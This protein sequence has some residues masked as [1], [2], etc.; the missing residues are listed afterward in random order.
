MSPADDT[1]PEET[2]ID[3]S[4]DTETPTGTPTDTETPTET[5]TETETETATD[6]E[7]PTETATEAEPATNGYQVRISYDGEWSGSIGGGGS[8]RS[9][10]G[11]G[12]QTLDVQ[13]D[14]NIVSANAQKQDDSSRRLTVEIL[15]DGEVVSDSATTAAYGVA[16]ATS[17]GGIGG[18]GD[19]DSDTASGGFEVRVEYGGEWSG[20]IN[21]GGS[22]RTVDGA[23]SQTLAVE[24]D[25]DIISANAQKQDDSDRTLTIQILRDG[26]VLK[27]TS[28][29][30]EYGVAQTTY[31][32]F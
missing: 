18:F 22:S 4:P 21:A 11:S 23:G 6:T 14:P 31:S 9:V 20:S 19:D 28:T 16:Q 10:D 7:E 26:E 25:P 8:T 29:S 24:G 1:E 15:R 13:G 3:D 17:D 12:T 30:A 27:E 5:D 32:A 2:P